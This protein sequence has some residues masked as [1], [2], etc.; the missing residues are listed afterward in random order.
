[1]EKLNLSWKSVLAVCF[2]GA[3]EMY[4]RISGVQSRCKGI[5][6]KILYVHCFERCLNLVLQ[7]LKNSLMF[8][9]FG[10]VQLLYNFIEGTR[11]AILEQISKIVATKL[12]ILKSLSRTRW[13]CRAEAVAALKLFPMSSNIALSQNFEFFIGIEL[14]H[15]ILQM[16]VK[17]SKL[18]QDPKL[19]ILTAMGE[20]R[21]LR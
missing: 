17:F 2:D 8:D 11:H 6:T 13:A 12:R 9:F 1:M 20:V 3:S 4:S 14:M 16:I 5:N 18:L 15:P 7:D 19:D 21:H 10:T